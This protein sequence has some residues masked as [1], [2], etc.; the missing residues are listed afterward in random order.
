MGRP[1]ERHLIIPQRVSTA[2]ISALRR[3]TDQPLELDAESLRALAT[4]LDPSDPVTARLIC[5]HVASV[6]GEDVEVGPYLT[7]RQSTLT[8]LG[9]VL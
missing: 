9:T 6:S 3:S 8:V 5:D 4:Y 7:D 1:S 2:W